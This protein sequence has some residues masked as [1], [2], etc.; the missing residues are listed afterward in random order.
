MPRQK[1][2]TQA[3]LGNK[4]RVCNLGEGQLTGKDKGRFTNAKWVRYKNF[5][6]NFRLTLKKLIY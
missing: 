2:K 1:P 3:I 6:L 5:I 4:I